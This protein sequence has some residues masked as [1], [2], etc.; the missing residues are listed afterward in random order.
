MSRFL[1]ATIC[2]VLLLPALARAENEGQADLDAAT[3]LQ[4][5]AETLGDL[6]KVIEKAE[7][8]LKKGLDDG[9]AEF[10]KQM[11]AATLYQ[12]ANRLSAAIFEQQPPSPKWPL[13]RQYALKDL[14]KAKTHDPKL[15]DIFLLTAKLQVLPG[16]DAKAATESIDEAV[17][18][19]KEKDQ[20]EELAKAYVLRA[21]LSEDND[22]KLA[23]F[24]AAIK[25]DDSNIQA[26]QGRALIYLEKGDN[27][28]AVADLTKL[29]EKQADNPAAVG[30]LAEALTN[31]K[32][33]DEALT[34]ADKVIEIAPKST[35]GYN[36]RA[37]IKVLKDDLKSA[38]EDLNKA[39][40]IDSKDVAALLMRSRLLA[41]DGKDA[42]AKADVEKALALRP[43]LPQGILM[44]SMLAAQKG[45]FAEAISDIQTL[46]HSDPQNPDYRL[47]L[48]TYM[49]ADKRP[50]R[51][52]E[53]LDALIEADAKN[54]D[55]LRARGDA[56]L[57][58]GKHAEAVVDYEN[59][60]KIDA[61]DTGVLNNLAWVLATSTDDKVRD[62][63]RAIEL[64]TKACELTKYEKPHIL[65]TLG[66]AYA[67]AGDWDKAIEWSN[68]AVEKGDGEVAAQLKEEQDSYKE[69]KPWREKQETEENT[70]PLEPMQSELE[71]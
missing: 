21:T 3:D 50:R 30:A 62:S 67:E 44:R 47:Q 12:H 5:A 39:I 69:K 20:P 42:E 9:Q 64:A 23:D 36:L 1:L 24:D 35:L 43:D 16:G 4:L 22:K 65:S 70:K 52:I 37:R 54:S 13:V 53:V 19:L 45:K 27:E 63:K 34:Y 28:K 33:Y 57:S 31:L 10:A 51:A 7:S 61:E 18:L 41:A 59:A 55:A 49:V 25:A 48:A 32:K 17:R 46:L 66:A 38:T 58:I 29:V 6:E 56:L 8:A 26:W 40:E 15:P 14:E 68:K 11:L 71:T 2:A 60:M